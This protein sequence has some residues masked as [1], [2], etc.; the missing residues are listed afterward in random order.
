MKTKSLIAVLL[1]ALLNAGA[2]ASMDDAEQWWRRWKKKPR[3]DLGEPAGGA[4]G[5]TWDTFYVRTDGANSPTCN[6]TTNAAA[7]GAS[8]NNCAWLTVDHAAKSTSVT[9]GDWIRVQPGDY[10]EIVGPGRNGTAGNP[11]TILA[12]GGLV[13][14]CGVSISDGDEYV[15]FVGLTIKGNLGSCNTQRLVVIGNSSTSTGIEFWHM[16]IRDGFPSGA[17]GMCSGDVVVRENKYLVIGNELTEIGMNLGE[18]DG[19]SNSTGIALRG[20]NNLF[21]YN[22]MSRVDPDLFGFIGAF[23]SRWLNNH[24]H[25]HVTDTSHGDIWQGGSSLL[26]TAFNLFEANFLLGDGVIEPVGG[27]GEHG[28]LFQDQQADGHANCESQACGDNTENLFRRNVNHRS[29]GSGHSADSCASGG[30]T[31]IRIVNDTFV[32][33]QLQGASTTGHSIVYQ[34]AENTGW[35]LNSINDNV[36]TLSTGM[37]GFTFQ[38]PASAPTLNGNLLYKNGVTLAFAAHW[39]AQPVKF[40]NQDPKFVDRPNDDFTLQSDSPVIG[41]AVALTTTSGSGTGVT[42]NV[43][44][45]T[46]GWFRGPDPVIDHYGGN[47]TEGDAILVG[48]DCRTVVSVSGDAITVDSSLTWADAEPVYYGCDSTPDGGA[49]SYRAGGYA[50]SATYSVTNGTVT[51]TP[52]DADLVRWVICYTDGVPY[53]V[54]NSSPFTCARAVGTFSALVYRRFA[55]PD[56]GAL[57]VEATQ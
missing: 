4:G 51:I 1:I 56:S 33:M 32:D 20:S 31:D 28:A 24:L 23:K 36:G 39:N 34:C 22:K 44:S 47:L 45:N 46:G 10:P 50:L 38:A 19:N 8:G 52:N 3:A 18:G 42:F 21:A 6:G 25:M 12:D 55:H 49:F 5:A 30:I 2:I 27:A 57:W 9:A 7:A 43:L 35:M 26:G 11:V 15:R 17:C 14:V 16:T 40:D 13:R 48:T 54:D 29:A 41:G 53:T 37:S